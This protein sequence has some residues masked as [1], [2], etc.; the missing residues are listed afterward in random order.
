LQQAADDA[1]GKVSKEEW[2]RLEKTARDARFSDDASFREDY[3]QGLILGYRGIPVSYFVSYSG[4]C[5]KCD[6]GLDYEFQKEL[7]P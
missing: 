5:T 3:E 1:Y 7:N 6:F 2:E 4:H